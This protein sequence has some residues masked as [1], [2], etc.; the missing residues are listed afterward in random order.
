MSATPHF[1]SIK[2]FTDLMMVELDLL[3]CLHAKLGTDR[4]TDE[5]TVLARVGDVD[6]RAE[7]DDIVSHRILGGFLDST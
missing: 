2:A 1:V 7:L 5:L 4:E 6:R 3:L